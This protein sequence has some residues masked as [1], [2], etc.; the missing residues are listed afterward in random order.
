L[1]DIRASFAM[2][3]ADALRWGPFAIARG[4]TF[5]SNHDLRDDLPAV[6]APT[7]LVWGERDRLVPPRV[8]AEW[9]WLLPAARIARLSCGHVPMLEAPRELAGCMLGFLDEGPADDGRDQ[10]GTRVVDGMR[11][12][13]HD[14]HPPAG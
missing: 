10:A 1:N 8:A 14:D 13:Q 11:L 3:G 2:V 4:I 5:V 12:A 6:R 7:L 9:Q